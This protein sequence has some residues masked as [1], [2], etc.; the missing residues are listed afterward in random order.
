MES[1]LKFDGHKLSESNRSAEKAN[2]QKSFDQAVRFRPWANGWTL[3][4]GDPDLRDLQDAS[5]FSAKYWDYNK[6]EV[7][8]FSFF[9]CDGKSIFLLLEMLGIYWILYKSDE[10]LRIR[11]P[12]CLSGTWKQQRRVEMI[13]LALKFS[14]FAYAARE[15][16]LFRYSK[17]GCKLKVQ[18]HLFICF[19]ATTQQRKKTN[20]HVNVWTKSYWKRSHY[21]PLCV[22]CE[23]GQNWVRTDVTIINVLWNIALY[24]GLISDIGIAALL[25]L[26]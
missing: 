22:K 19:A 15:E 14:L 16:I 9:S 18:L 21:N 23:G 20:G 2:T 12:K 3:Q 26:H 24:Y 6:Q 11:Q 1:D 17:E 4:N 7:I 13:S 25:C 5:V 10:G 8:S